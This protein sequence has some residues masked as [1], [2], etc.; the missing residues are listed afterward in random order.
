[1]ANVMVNCG[2]AAGSRWLAA[3]RLVGRGA[4]ALPVVR[5][6]SVVGSSSPS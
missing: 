2:D 3:D 4:M 6:I 5:A 1:L